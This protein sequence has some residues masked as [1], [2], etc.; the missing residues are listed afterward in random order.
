MV[1]IADYLQFRQAQSFSL[2]KE[3]F[4][5]CNIAQPYKPYTFNVSYTQNKA[6]AIN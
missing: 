1:Q 3:P 2:G 6:K 5:R 4:I